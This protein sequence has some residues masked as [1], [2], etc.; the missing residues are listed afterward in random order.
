[1]WSIC[2]AG[3]SGEEHYEGEESDPPWLGKGKICRRG[4]EL[5]LSIV[6]L[7]LP[8]ITTIFPI[9][10]SWFIKR[11]LSLP[12]SC[13]T[14]HYFNQ[15][16]SSFYVQVHKWKDQYGG[17]ICQ[18]YRRLGASL[19]WSREVCYSLFWVLIFMLARFLSKLAMHSCL[20][21]MV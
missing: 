8:H 4:L 2:G 20:S 5:S 15:S 6:W 10:S 17:Q 19:D 3:G 18:Q 21:L 14:W 7:F 16:D 9:L 11:Y 13:L 1:M 12:F